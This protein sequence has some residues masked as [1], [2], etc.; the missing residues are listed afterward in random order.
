MH[1]SDS[2]DHEIGRLVLT[3]FLSVQIEI[4]F[5]VRTVVPCGLVYDD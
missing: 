4:W 5:S 1:L 3:L 2:S